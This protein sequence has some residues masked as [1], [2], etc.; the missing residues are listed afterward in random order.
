[1]ASVTNT[2][3][4]AFADVVID[5]RLDAGKVLSEAQSL[6]GLVASS[7][8]LRE[9]W[10]APSIPA[11]Q[12]RNLLDAIVAREKMSRELRN[13]IAVLIDH[14]RINFLA[15]VIKQFEH[16]LNQ[17]MGFA[18]AEITS[19]RELADGERRALEAEVEKLIGR[20]VRAH[21]SQDASILGGATVK[22]GSTIYDGSVKGQLEKIR[23]QLAGSTVG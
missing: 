2:Y 5:R 18:E 6:A 12:K 17:R 7:K 11:E 23:E 22:V 13:F 3:A 14:R 15:A 20:K 19:A 16:E 9:V 4:R 10:E 8:E 1:M 21:Y